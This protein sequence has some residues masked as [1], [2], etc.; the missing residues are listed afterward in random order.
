MNCYSPVENGRE[1][2][3]KTRTRTAIRPS[4][5]TAG[6]IFK[7][8]EITVPKRHTHPRFTAAL[9]TIAETRKQPS[10]HQCKCIKKKYIHKHICTQCN[11]SHKKEEN[12]VMY[13]TVDRPQ[14]H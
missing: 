9:F 10:V 8:N 11:I 2:L 1:V 3:P 5:P 7:E 4:D 12:P 14:G 6:Y 13:N